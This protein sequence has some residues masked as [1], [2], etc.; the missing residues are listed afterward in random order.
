VLTEEGHITG[1][2]N[3]PSPYAKKRWWG[4]GFS[5]A[6]PPEAWTGMQSANRG[7]WWPDWVAWLAQNAP[8]TGPAP[9]LGSL[10]YPVLASAP[11]TYVLEP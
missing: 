6:Q 10:T 9:G 1:I 7:S 2:V 5:A 11:G 4:G 3:P 8:Q